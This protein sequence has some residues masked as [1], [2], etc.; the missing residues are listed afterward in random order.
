MK[1]Y[2]LIT[3]IMILVVVGGYAA[4]SSGILTSLFSNE[5][6]NPFSQVSGAWNGDGWYEGGLQADARLT[7]DSKGIWTFTLTD[8]TMYKRGIKGSGYT[9]I[10]GAGEFHFEFDNSKMGAISTLKF[11]GPSIVYKDIARNSF[12][13]RK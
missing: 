1:K 4:Y 6:D 9:V 12:T 5:S 13:V 3:S 11:Q 8:R 7:I 2:I 10:D